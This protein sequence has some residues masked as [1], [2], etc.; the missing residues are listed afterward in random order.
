MIE[1]SRWTNTGKKWLKGGRTCDVTIYISFCS[2]AIPSRFTATWSPSTGFDMSTLYLLKISR[3]LVSFYLHL[4][5]HFLWNIILS[6]EQRLSFYVSILHIA[7]WSALYSK[8]RAFPALKTN[9]NFYLFFFGLS[10]RNVSWI[11]LLFRK[12]LRYINELRSF[13]S[14]NYTNRYICISTGYFAELEHCFTKQ[15]SSIMRC[16]WLKLVK[17]FFTTIVLSDACSTQLS[18]IKKKKRKKIH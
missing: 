5:H 13:V 9:Y 17:S 1:C 16:T 14:V 10:T 11:S 7:W 4:L 6:F 12:L 15:Y 2:I 8:Q 3:N 18:S